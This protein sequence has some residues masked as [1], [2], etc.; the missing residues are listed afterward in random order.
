MTQ[1]FFYMMLCF[2]QYQT[3][4]S[5]SS[6]SPVLL[7]FS[8]IFCAIVSSNF[9]LQLSLFLILTYN[10]SLYRNTL[11]SFS[12]NS[13][14]KVEKFMIFSREFPVSLKCET[15]TLSCTIEFTSLS[16]HSTSDSVTGRPEYS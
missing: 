13:S 14:L 12:L 5:G 6:S 16:T 15:I 3:E 1:M 7:I 9:S 11:D 4:I 8:L 10:S 2:Q